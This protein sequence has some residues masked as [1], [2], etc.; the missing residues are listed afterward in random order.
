[1]GDKVR[2][3]VSG[4]IEELEGKATRKA[5]KPVTFSMRLS[6]RD[7][8]KLLWLANSLDVPK[9]PLAEDLLK[10]AV[11]EAIEQ[12]A[13]WASSED[14]EGFLNEA[15][16]RI[17]IWSGAPAPMTRRNHRHR[18][19][20]NRRRHG[21]VIDRRSPDASA[22]KQSCTLCSPARSSWLP[23]PLCSLARET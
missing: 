16:K 9:T 3:L 19:T 8:A 7:H 21:R 18:R 1:M 20:T 13:G 12:Y 23:W 11:D 22:H 10:A 15:L 14:P 4:Y 6:E 2:A 5:P 17:E